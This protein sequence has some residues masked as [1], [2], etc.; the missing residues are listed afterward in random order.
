MFETVET[1][2]NA[3]SLCR[4]KSWECFSLVSKYL[5]IVHYTFIRSTVAL[6][7]LERLPI[8]PTGQA[9]MT[10]VLARRCPLKTYSSPAV[11]L[12]PYPFPKLTY[13]WDHVQLLGQS[14]GS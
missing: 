8:V 6:F 3:A 13:G 4:F 1:E 14:F 9:Q 10:R 7:P 12:L 5:F 2:G 11:L